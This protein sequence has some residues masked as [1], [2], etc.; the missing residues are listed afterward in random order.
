MSPQPDAPLTQDELV[1]LDTFLLSDACDDEALS[2]DEA[3]GFITASIAGP[4]QLDQDEWMAAVWG[5][6]GFADD[7]EQVRKTGLLL[8]LYDEI[9]AILRSGRPYEPLAVEMEEEDGESIEAYEGWCF[10]F[11]VGVS[12]RQALWERLPKDEQGLLAPIAQL[13]LLAGDEESDMDD[14]EYASWVELLPGAVAGLYAYWHGAQGQ[15]P[16]QA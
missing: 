4:E 2:I 5:E 11:M 15:Q 6:P 8:R 7:A 14:E 13:A 10:G 9:A 12:H 16:R 3:H 1:E